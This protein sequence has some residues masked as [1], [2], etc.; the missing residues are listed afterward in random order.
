MTPS[1]I[2]RWRH[3]PPYIRSVVLGNQDVNTIKQY[4]NAAVRTGKDLWMTGGPPCRAPIDK[5]LNEMRHLARDLVVIKNNYWVWWMGWWSSFGLTML[6][7]LYFM[8]I[9]LIRPRPRGSMFSKGC[10]TVSVRVM[11]SSIW[12]RMIRIWSERQHKY[13]Y[14]GLRRC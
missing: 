8:V 11:W 9:H 3:Y 14:G 6:S 12:R 10:G 5:T 4:S 1:S 13:R 7:R 2:K